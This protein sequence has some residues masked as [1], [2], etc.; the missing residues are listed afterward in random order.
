M[1]RQS[2]EVL[3]GWGVPGERI[4][5]A[6]NSADTGELLAR[7]DEPQAAE[8]VA[9]IR[10][11]VAGGRRL[12]IV[13]GRLV[14]LKGIEPLLAAWQ[15][16]PSEVRRE[17]RL[18]FVGDGPL[19]SLVDRAAAAGVAAVGFVQREE[20]ADWYRAADLTIFASLGDVWGLVVNE[21]LACGTPVLCSLHAAAC[22]DLIEHGENGLVF[23]PADREGT[24]SALAEALTRP[25]LERLGAAGP[26]AE[27]R[28]SL[29]GLVDAFR[30]AVERATAVDPEI[31]RTIGGE[32][33]GP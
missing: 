22:D 31:R 13:V 21:S 9:A 16:L 11:R 8:R 32:P 28:C 14:P 4:V 17:W 3:T 7:L 25:D 29:E 18:V 5:E 26:A 6:L 20:I 12:A 23:D 10:E 33:A 2:R 30:S 24:V 27:A 19:R 1:G 15:R